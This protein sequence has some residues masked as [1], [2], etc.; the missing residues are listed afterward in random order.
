MQELSPEAIAYSKNLTFAFSNTFKDQD[1][2]LNNY[3]QF[4]FIIDIDGKVYQGATANEDS[5]TIV[6]IGGIDQFVNAKS[7]TVYSNF[8]ITEQQKVTLYKVIKELARYTNTAVISSDNEKLE[9]SITALYNNYC[10]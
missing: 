7:N 4:T 5:A 8:Y 10:G 6:I 3:S 9:Q 1:I 2:N